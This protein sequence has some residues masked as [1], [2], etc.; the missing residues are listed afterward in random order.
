MRRASFCSFDATEKE[1]LAAYGKF[2]P[3]KPLSAVPEQGNENITLKEAWNKHLV[4]LFYRSPDNF[5]ESFFFWLLEQE[6]KNK[7]LRVERIVL[8]SISDIERTTGSGTAFQDFM[9][10]LLALL[11]RSGV[12]TLFTCESP[13][14]LART[15]FHGTPISYMADNI[16]LTAQIPINDVNRKCILVVKSRGQP[17]L[18]NPRELVILP[19]AS[20]DDLT[21][22]VSDT[23][24]EYSQLLHGRP[25][26]VQIHLR[27]FGENE[28]EVQFNKKF[29][30]DL[31]SRYP[32][33]RFSTFTK[34]DLR[35]VLWEHRGV[36]RSQALHSDITVVSI[37]EPWFAQLALPHMDVD[38][39]PQES[40]L[41]RLYVHGDR[42]DSFRKH[43]LESF[44]P[45]IMLGSCVKGKF[46]GLPQYYDMGFLFYRTDALNEHGAKIPRALG[47]IA[48]MSQTCP[49]PNSW[50]QMVAEISRRARMYGFAVETSIVD[51]LVCPFIELCWNYG[52]V[53]DFLENQAYAEEPVKNALCALAWLVSSGYMPYPCDNKTTAEAVF[54]RHWY[55]TFQDMLLS[56]SAT[57]SQ[58]GIVRFP[59]SHIEDEAQHLLEERIK[60]YAK[61][62]SCDPGEVDLNANSKTNNIKNSVDFVASL[63][64]QFARDFLFKNN[65]S[66]WDVSDVVLKGGWACSGGW[67]TGVLRCGRS[68]DP[69]WIIASELVDQARVIRRAYEG[70]GLPPTKDFFEG[71]WH[72]PVPNIEATTFGDLHDEFFPCVRHRYDTFGFSD[73]YKASLAYELFTDELYGILAEFLSKCVRNMPKEDDIKKIAGA[74]FDKAKVA[75]EMV[76]LMV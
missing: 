21:C 50:L 34:T 54:C 44:L 27:L 73:S 9:T 74:I 33:I 16:I 35:E 45:H 65:G 18:S 67:Y 15:L 51:N 62:V 6:V 20:G 42:I 7:T 57:K 75:T 70:A 49:E 68:V 48:D 28:K 41:A 11:R 60:L 10:N 17:S 52:A 56:N 31:R 22:R 2:R 61:K 36:A 47:T 64:K 39:I 38:P 37:D 19:S 40:V 24:D 12:T 13:I 59:V 29:V 55:S 23:F 71:N 69:G 72:C 32:K 3:P 76:R 46:Y 63:R 1:L 58:Y 30:D 8:D 25:E 53:P 14:D 5:D 43:H 26:P 66:R 4:R